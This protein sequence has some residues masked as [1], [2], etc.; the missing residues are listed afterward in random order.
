MY[1]GM[2]GL[3]VCSGPGEVEVFALR[4]L[5]LGRRA[6]GLGTLIYWRSG[7]REA[8]CGRGDVEV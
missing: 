8:C 3:E 4:D 7:T 6:V 1:R 5:E 2:E